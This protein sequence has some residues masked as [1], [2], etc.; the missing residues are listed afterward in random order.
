MPKRH[1]RSASN[2]PAAEGA[3]YERILA[4]IFDHRLPPETK[5]GEDRLAAIFG[6]SR[7]RASGACCR[8]LRTKA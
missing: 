2:A 7:A 5:L 8:G 3:I 4:A 6:V 1:G